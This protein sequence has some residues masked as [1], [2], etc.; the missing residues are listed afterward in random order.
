MGAS[1][2]SKKTV[3]GWRSLCGA[4][5]RLPKAGSNRDLCAPTTNLQLGDA[6]QYMAL[7]S[8][9][10]IGEKGTTEDLSN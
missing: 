7:F 6:P 4:S 9:F 1:Q 10:I 3:V 8:L 5:E 2:R